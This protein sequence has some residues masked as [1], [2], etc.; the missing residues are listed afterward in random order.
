MIARD[1]LR[2][3]MVVRPPSRAAFTAYL[4]GRTDFGCR[5]RRPRF[6]PTRSG[7]TTT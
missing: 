2:P 7:T 6:R 3:P 1:D 4:K 5:R